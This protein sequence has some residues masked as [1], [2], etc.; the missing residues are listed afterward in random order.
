LS[1]N[2]ESIVEENLK[3]KTTCYL[4]QGSGKLGD[5]AIESMKTIKMR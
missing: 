4:C 2:D 1:N 3:T 5:D